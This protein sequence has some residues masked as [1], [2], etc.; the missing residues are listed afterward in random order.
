MEITTTNDAAGGAASTASQ[1]NDAE[2]LRRVQ[3]DDLDAFEE[4]FAR[5]R[6]PIYRTAYGLTGDR[7]AA[8]EILQ[9]TFARAYRHRQHVPQRRLA[10]A[11]AAPRVAEPLLL[12]AVAPPA[13]REPDRRDRRAHR[14]D[15]R[16]LPAERAEQAELRQIVREGIAALPEKHRSVVVLY[17]LHRLS[18]QETAQVLGI[19]LGTVKS[20]L[21]Y[22]LRSLRVHLEAR[23]P[24]RRRLPARRRGRGQGLVIEFRGGVRPPP[25]G[26]ARLRRPRRDRRRHRA[27]PRP[28]RA[29]QPLHGGA[30]VDG[31]RD[32]G[33]PPLRRRAGPRR[34]VAGS[35]AAAPR[36]HRDPPA[37]TL[38]DHV[39]ERGHGHEHRPRRGPR[40][41]V[42]G[43]RLDH[44][45]RAPTYLPIEPARRLPR[46]AP[47]R[48]RLLAKIRHGHVPHEGAGEPAGR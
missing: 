9:D 38:G 5:Y 6:N 43:R 37:G 23:P 48:G 2:L 8:E 44:E 34:A 30:R 13:R 12:A 31:P 28:P 11:V 14:A 41:P 36:P 20:R 40:R 42:P 10:V 39:A 4:F 33:P 1:K 18:L 3:A 45:L 29:L 46:G 15:D 35:L 22:A 26:A 27:G 32:H 17:Y 16:P 21:H 25:C 7:Q 19:Q 24:L 47:D